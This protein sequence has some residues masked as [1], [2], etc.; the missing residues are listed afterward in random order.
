MIFSNHP[1]T[2]S[3][4]S[5]LTNSSNLKRETFITTDNKASS[6][7]ANIRFPIISSNELMVQYSVMF[8]T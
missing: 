1:I 5:N 6:L 2:G 7:I 3:F 8:A 4:S